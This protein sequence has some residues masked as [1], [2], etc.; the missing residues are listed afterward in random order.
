VGTEISLDISGLSVDWSKNAR[1]ADHGVLFQEG[2]RKRLRSEQIDYDYFSDS[3][4]DPGP[5]EIA[6]ARR[7]KHVVPR[8]DLVGYTLEAAKAEYLVV[9]QSWL[10]ERHDLADDAEL[11]DVMSF[12][13]FCAFATAHPIQTLDDTFVSSVDSAAKDRVRGRFTDESVVRRLPSSPIDEWSAYS[14]RSY[15]GGL[16]S[17]LHPYSLSA[18]AG[19]QRR[20][21]RNRGRL[22]IRAA[23]GGRLGQ[24]K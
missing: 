8:L 16:I 24:R 19:W 9:A 6:L 5:M 13:E 20:E 18:R 21:L 23:R 2:D 11:P 4:E 17:I 10:E 15:F 22:A 14:E 1:G 12:E 7:L 3:G